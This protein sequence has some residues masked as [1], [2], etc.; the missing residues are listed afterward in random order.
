V[1]SRPHQVSTDAEL[2]VAALRALARRAHSVR[3]MR[4]YLER[5]T[6]ATDAVSRVL[7][8]LQ[9]EKFLDDERY[10]LQAAR[11]RSHTR[12]QGPGRIARELR[13]RGVPDSCIES[14]LAALTLETDEASMVRAQLRRRLASL[15]GPLDQRRVASLYRSMMR[16][17]FSM[18]TVRRELRLLT[19][20]EPAEDLPPSESDQELH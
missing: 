18:D 4:L 14:A 15:R 5:R 2:Y 6:H 11:S 13:L 17:G 8:R 19:K 12:R 16:A 9:Q 10:A 1:R 20:L 7:D 3:E